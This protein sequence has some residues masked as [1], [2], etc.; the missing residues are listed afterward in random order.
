MREFYAQ[1]ASLD[2]Q[3]LVILNVENAQKKLAMPLG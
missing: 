1:N 2:I 3:E